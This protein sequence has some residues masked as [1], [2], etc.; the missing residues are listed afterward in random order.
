MRKIENEKRVMRRGFVGERA[1]GKKEG[2]ELQER[3]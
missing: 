1:Q 3:G 2:A